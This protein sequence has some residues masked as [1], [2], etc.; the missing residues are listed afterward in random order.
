MC[1]EIKN[2]IYQLYEYT[3]RANYVK[4]KRLAYLQ[5]SEGYLTTLRFILK[6]ARNQKYLSKG[7]YENLDLD[8]TEISK[9]LTGYI[10]ATITK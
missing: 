6:V 9:M 5:E 8:L 1:S 10:K 7:A 2:C 3:D 4:S